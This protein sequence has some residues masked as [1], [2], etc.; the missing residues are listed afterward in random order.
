M[1]AVLGKPPSPPSA[2]EKATMSCHIGHWRAD[3]GSLVV[4][5]YL[6]IHRFCRRWT[7]NIATAFTVNSLLILQQAASRMGHRFLSLSV[8]RVPVMQNSL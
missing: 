4:V 7:F 5:T 1:L 3:I 6:C 8:Y 2:L